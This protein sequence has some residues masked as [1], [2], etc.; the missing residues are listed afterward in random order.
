[1]FGITSAAEALQVLTTAT[2]IAT[3]VAGFVALFC[4][5]RLFVG[6]KTK[7]KEQKTRD[8]K[9]IFIPLIVIGIYWCL[10]FIWGESI[11]AGYG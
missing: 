2:W 10:F 6:F 3:G 8:F 4:L 9:E 5:F 1:M 7:S 11:A